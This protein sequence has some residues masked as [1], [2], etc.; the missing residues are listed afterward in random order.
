MIAGFIGDQVSGGAKLSVNYHLTKKN[1]WLRNL[2]LDKS[3]VVGSL[4]AI[5]LLSHQN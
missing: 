1:N 3:W 5:I 4:E 2:T